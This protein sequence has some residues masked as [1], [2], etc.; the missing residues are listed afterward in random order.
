MEV[1]VSRQN[2]PRVVRLPAVLIG[3]TSSH[4]FPS[5]KKI[6]NV[7]LT[8]KAPDASAAISTIRSNLQTDSRILL[9]CNGALAVREEIQMQL[10]HNPI[11]VISTT[12]GAYREES[13]DELYHVTHAG[14]GRTYVQDDAPLARLFDQSGLQA[15][16]T[17]EMETMLWLKLAA[18]CT[19]NPITAILGCRNG[20][21]PLQPEFQ[22]MAPSILKEICNVCPDETI[23][24]T[25]LQQF[26]DQVIQDTAHNKSSML[27]D[28]ENRRATE[29]AYLNG[30]VVKKGLA[31]GVPTPVN[32]TICDTIMGLL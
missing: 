1:C 15:E 9:L 6:R 21:L 4:S 5:S 26:V 16:S 27:Q 11:T 7:L 32:Q 25:R 18:N 2:R 31:L 3:D 29:V 23:T 13:D 10:P 14:I 22:T 24:P 17:I 28:V 30:F 19:I 12:H 8:T 20:D